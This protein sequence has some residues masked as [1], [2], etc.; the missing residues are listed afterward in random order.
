ML[1]TVNCRKLK[2]LAHTNRPPKS[3]AHTLFFLKNRS[4][5]TPQKLA[6][7][8]WKLTHTLWKLAHTPWKLAHTREKLAHTPCQV[9]LRSC[10]SVFQRVLSARAP[11]TAAT[12]KRGIGAGATSAILHRVHPD[13]KLVSSRFRQDGVTFCFGGPQTHPMFFCEFLCFEADMC[14]ERYIDVCRH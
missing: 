14:K 4:A 12:H 10:K 11:R 3:S 8:P 13:C 7:T 6:H 9:Y 5:H 1:Y 2:K